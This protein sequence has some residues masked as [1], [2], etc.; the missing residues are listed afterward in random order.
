VVRLSAKASI[1]AVDLVLLAMFAVCAVLLL[2]IIL[3]AIVRNRETMA[4]VPGKLFSI[5]CLRAAFATL[6]G[7]LN[8]AQQLD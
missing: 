4:A 6:G 7:R 2:W 1:A 5:Y 8:P 3:R